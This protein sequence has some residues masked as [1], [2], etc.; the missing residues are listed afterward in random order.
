[1]VRSVLEINKPASTSNGA[2]K[3][4]VAGEVQNQLKYRLGASTADKDKLYQS[5]EAFVGGRRASLLHQA[6]AVAGSAA[7]AHA[8]PL[9]RPLRAVAWS[10][11]NRLVDAFDKT[12]E[13]WE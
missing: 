5:G 11:H 4:D 6:P 13:H 10:V 2:G 8:R 3:L 1:M 9:A 7:C 12:H